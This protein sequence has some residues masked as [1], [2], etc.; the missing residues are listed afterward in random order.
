MLKFICLICLGFSQGAQ[1]FAPISCTLPP[2]KS[3]ILGDQSVQ[4][5]SVVSA[6]K[7]QLEGY[8][9]REFGRGRRF[10]IWSSRR[11]AIEFSTQWSNTHLIEALENISGVSEAAFILA[12]A[13][14]VG[15]NMPGSLR[16]FT[17]SLRDGT[18]NPTQDY[19]VICSIGESK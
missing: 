15:E 12:V 17:S 3:L 11:Y 8:G 5:L 19:P 14:Q 13:A 16:V 4:K 6:K 10:P 2:G 9:V 7:L 18:E 1:A